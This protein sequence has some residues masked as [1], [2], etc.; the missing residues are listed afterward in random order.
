MERWTLLAWLALAAVH[1]APVAVLV[2]P[3]AA[4]R[5]YGVDPHGPAGVL[6][7]HRGALFLGLVVLSAWAAFDPGARRAAA[8]VVG[9]SVAGFL[10]VY[11][12]A[13]LPPGALRTVALVDAAALV[14]LAWAAA[15]AWA[16]PR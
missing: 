3:E 10:A 8:L 1:A 16:G 6:I 5:L 4:R 13:G 14:P 12:R 11:L 2:A 15:Q 7:V 9:I